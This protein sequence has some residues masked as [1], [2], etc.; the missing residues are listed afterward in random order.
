MVSP[1]P[2]PSPLSFPLPPPFLPHLPL[3]SALEA[4]P[5][6]VF[7][8]TLCHPRG[9][10]DVGWR[11]RGVRGAAE[12]RV[13]WPRT[14]RSQTERRVPPGR[15]LKWSPQNQ[16]TDAGVEWGTKETQE[17][18]GDGISKALTWASG[19]M[20]MPF[21]G[22]RKAEGG[23]MPAIVLGGGRRSQMELASRRLRA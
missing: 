5:V 18:R 20:V 22:Q 8:S 19:Q 16:P 13:A 17:S 6:F 12:T 15:G 21:V 7:P 10:E 3:S 23:P 14:E 9:E 11:A 1:H 4:H 2:S